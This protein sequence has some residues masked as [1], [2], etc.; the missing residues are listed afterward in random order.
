[1]RRGRNCWEIECA[2]NGVGE[3]EREER[4]QERWMDA[5]INWKINNLRGK[6]LEAHGNEKQGGSRKQGA[7]RE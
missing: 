5:E 7:T 6:K 4:E 2:S 3:K 1:M